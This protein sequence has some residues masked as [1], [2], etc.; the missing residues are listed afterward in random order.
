MEDKKNYLLPA[1]ILVSTVVF[2]GSWI[3]TAGLESQRNQTAIQPRA[4]VA[5]S[6]L[7]EKVLLAEGVILPVVWGDLG[8]K[9]VDAGA[10]DAERFKAIYDQR[11]E[12]TEEY[13]NLLLGENKVKLKITKDN[14]GYLLNL[15]WALGLA[16]NNP[17][18]DSGEMKNPAYG[19]AQNF[20]ST[21]GWTMA[22]GNPMDHY[23]RHKFFLLTPEQ[24]ALVDKVSRG[25]YRPCCGNSTHFPDCNHG[26]AMLGFLELMASQGVNEQDIWNAALAANSYWFPETYLTLAAYM[27]NRGVDWEN[28][29]PQEILGINFSSASGY[30]KILSESKSFQLKNSSGCGI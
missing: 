19:G 12:F 7:E 9:L 16:S 4:E 27:K 29:N 23:S 3:Y 28:A 21:A 25:I 8:K 17:I 26:M 24:Q 18:L 13:K 11:G 15:F 5:A 1:S 10:I 22:K 30:Q 20:A 6:A 2:A 14:A